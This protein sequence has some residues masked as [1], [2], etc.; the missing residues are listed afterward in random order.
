MV[1]RI[2]IF[3]TFALGGEVILAEALAEI[4]G[5]LLVGSGVYTQQQVDSMSWGE[6]SDIV[7]TDINNG[8]INPAQVKIT[9]PVTSAQMSFIEYI[10][11]DEVSAASAVARAAAKTWIKDKILDDD[12]AAEHVESYCDDVGL[13]G[14]NALLYF[15]G[16]SLIGYAYCDYIVIST[17]YD[18]ATRYMAYADKIYYREYAP[19]S[20]QWSEMFYSISMGGT[21][22]T[23]KVM[24]AYGD[25]RYED[26]TQIST[27]ETVSQVGETEDGTAVTTDMLN[28]DGTVTIDGVTYYPLDYLDFDKFDDTAIIDLLNQILLEIDNAAVVEGDN[29]ITN[30]I[31]QDISVELDID[32]LSNFQMSTGIS[33]VFP[34]CLPFDFVRGIELFSAKPVAPVFEI[35]FNIPSFGLFPGFESTITLDMSEYSEYF[36]VGRWVQVILF[37]IGLC[38]ISFKIVK[39]VH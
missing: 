13:S 39:G 23:Y 24:K 20:E 35:P 12:Y 34:F 2:L 7:S 3:N 8:T 31:T 29:T 5:L 28:A 32:S 19:Y 11:S 33:S 30:D 26:G 6:M 21:T 17:D 37:S 27:A 15:E 4:F 1:I 14:Y 22:N 16:V 10:C 18:G 38:F 9:D 36:E 25:V